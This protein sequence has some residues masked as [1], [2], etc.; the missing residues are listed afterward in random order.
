MKKSFTVSYYF[1]CPSR[2][3]TRKEETVLAD[4]I[5]EVHRKLA[6]LGPHV[7]AACG[8]PIPDG[9]PILSDRIREL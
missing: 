3:E 5:N 8:E 2:H 6:H 4:D 1:C 7:C 9:T